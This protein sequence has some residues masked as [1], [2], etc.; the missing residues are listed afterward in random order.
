MR[1]YPIFS[2][3][4]DGG[5][6]LGLQRQTP[7]QGAEKTPTREPIKKLQVEQ[8]WERDRERLG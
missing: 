8:L 1:D 6:V 3:R 4:R 5:K 7:E 2:H